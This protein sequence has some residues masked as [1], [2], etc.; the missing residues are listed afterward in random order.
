MSGSDHQRPTRPNVAIT[1]A[2]MLD[3]NIKMALGK[4]ARM[5]AF[6]F[7]DD[8]VTKAR[9]LREKPS[10]KP[11]LQKKMHLSRGSSKIYNG[12]LR[13]KISPRAELFS[14]LARAKKSAVRVKRYLKAHGGEA[15][16]PAHIIE[17][18]D[19]IEHMKQELS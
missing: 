8:V 3:R 5:A 18:M 4:A 1:A 16:P 17:K 10:R 2:G 7:M 11:K 9:S 19:F 6:S 13:A 15:T 12:L 14:Q